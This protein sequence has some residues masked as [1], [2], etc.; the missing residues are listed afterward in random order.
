MVHLMCSS[1]PGHDSQIYRSVTDCSNIKH[2]SLMHIPI[3]CTP[4]QGANAIIWLEVTELRVISSET[5]HD[6]KPFQ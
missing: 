6:P 3:V 1:H 4:R 5:Q 2:I